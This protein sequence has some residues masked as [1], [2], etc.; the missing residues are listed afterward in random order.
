[1]SHAS[2]FGFQGSGPGPLEFVAFFPQD[3]SV[4]AG[5][6][7]CLRRRL[8]VNDSFDTTSGTF[9]QAASQGSNTY[10]IVRTQFCFE[11]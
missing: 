4:V 5:P 2:A 3:A 1:M 7:N 11:S 9:A 8:G 10:N 6:L